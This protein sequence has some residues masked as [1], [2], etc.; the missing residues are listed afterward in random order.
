MAELKVG[1]T[2]QLQTGAS[3]KILQEL[4]QGGQGYVYKVEHD[5]GKEY[6]LRWYKSPDEWMYTNIGKLITKGAP[7]DDFIWPQM[8]TSKKDDIFG[9]IME[10]RPPEYQNIIKNIIKGRQIVDFNEYSNPVLPKITVAMKICDA[11]KK[12]HASGFCF[13]DINDDSFFVNPADGK[14]LIC[15]CDNV[16]LEGEHSPIFGKMRYMAPEIVMGNN[17]PNKR[18]DYFSLSVI[19]F[20]LLY[21]NHPFEGAQ[22]LRYFTPDV[23]KE[24]YGQN[25]VFVCDPTNESNRPVKNIHINVLNWWQFYP[26]TLND[27]F[28]RAFSKDAI[29]NPN[30]RIKETE[31]I[32]ILCKTRDLLE[33]S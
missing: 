29:T 17:L 16:I 8:L 7:S 5:S 33:N 30:N 2:I 25:A 13:P 12:L 19:L 24:V 15:G 21:G 20:L 28:V 18:T 4:G 26:K 6:A 14:V 31:W 10:L 27:T 22:A 32:N 3:L 1:E 23:E 9:Y 11:L